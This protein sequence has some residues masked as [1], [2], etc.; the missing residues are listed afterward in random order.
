MILIMDYG[1]IGSMG[2][3][4]FKEGTQNLKVFLPKYQYPHRKLF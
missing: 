2:C 3:R 1:D 4:V